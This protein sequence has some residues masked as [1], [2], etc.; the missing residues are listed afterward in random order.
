MKVKTFCIGHQA[1]LYDLPPEVIYISMGSY[2]HDFSQSLHIRDI[3]T[4]AD[5]HHPFLAS[6]AGI[7][8]IYKIL[9]NSNESIDIVRILSYRRF[10]SKQEFGLKSSHGNSRVITSAEFK[11]NN[12]NLLDESLNQPFIFAGPMNFNS[13]AEQYSRCHH[14]PDLLRYLAISIKHG[15]IS[16]ED[17]LPFLSNQFFIPYAMDLGQMPVEFFVNNVKKL[18]DISLDFINTHLP[19]NLQPY[20]RRAVNFCNE[21]MGSYLIQKFLM[22]NYKIIPNEFIAIPYLINED[23]I[24]SQNPI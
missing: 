15:L 20:Q 22:E 3:D 12:I 14:S 9:A 1:P 5:A 18:R 13:I 8:S 10:F 23:L 4:E 7:F 19:I 24:Y 16:S 11:K 6:S 21:R 2:H 17:I